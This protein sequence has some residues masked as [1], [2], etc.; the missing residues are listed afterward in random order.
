MAMTEKSGISPAWSGANDVFTTQYSGF[1]ADLHQM[2]CLR[3]NFLRIFVS[4]RASRIHAAAVACCDRLSN[5]TICHR[6]TLCPQKSK[7]PWFWLQSLFLLALSKK[8]QLLFWK[9][10]QSRF[11]LSTK[12]IAGRRSG[13]ARAFTL[14]SDSPISG[15]RG[16]IC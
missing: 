10:N 15:S 13:V 9:Y 5:K 6:R 4:V 2:L 16:E 8:S 3:C 14:L 7:S 11:L 12:N 1:L